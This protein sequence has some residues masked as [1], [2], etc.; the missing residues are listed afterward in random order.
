MKT[1]V[2]KRASEKRRTQGVLRPLIEEL[3][4]RPVRIDSQADIDFL[5]Y[6]M[7][8]MVER[9][10]A[11]A[12]NLVFS[13]SG[14]ASC[15]RRVYLGR[16]WKELGLQRI[17]LPSVQTHGI[18]L[19]G[20]FVH[21]KWHFIL[22][23]LGLA[24]PDF[25]LVDV[26]VPVMSKRKDHGGTLDAI[27]L[28][29]DVEPIVIDYKGLNVRNFQNAINGLPHDY[30]IQITDYV[31]LANS[32][33]RISEQVDAQEL[34]FP[35][36]R[37]VM[38]LENK[39]GPDSSHPLALHEVIVDRDGNLPDVQVRLEVLREHE[40]REEI[41]APE[42]VSTKSFQ[43]LGCPFAAFCKREVKAI[44]REQRAKGGD[45]DGLRVARPKRLDRSRRSGA[46]RGKDQ[47]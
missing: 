38:L 32:A 29:A 42:C 1:A 23:K 27:G 45:S 15:L 28:L 47:T 44:E 9:E 22:W 39:G 13:P 18:F 25:K 11:R 16:H 6:V 30:R 40:A 5:N 35:I 4:T 10:N 24:F 41:P 33:K 26:E 8:K 37:G 31:M 43:Y 2:E 21:L 20:D 46:R 34:R 17:E 12:D 7:S 14:L 36:K 3:F 19:N